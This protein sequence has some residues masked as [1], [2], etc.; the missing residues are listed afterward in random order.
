MDLSISFQLSPWIMLFFSHF[1]NLYFPTPRASGRMPRQD[2]GACSGS[3]CQGWG[4][5][6][7]G[8]LHCGTM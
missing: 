8:A 1:I 5:S 2:T 7:G 4:E 6:E 3:S